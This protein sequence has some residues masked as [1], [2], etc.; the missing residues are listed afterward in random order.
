MNGNS[1]M[2]D[3]DV[4]RAVGDSLSGMPATPPP[5][6]EMIKAR[7][8]AH[9]RRQLIPG[10]AGAAVVAAGAAALAVTTLTPASHPTTRPHAQLAAWTVAKQADGNVRVTIHELRDASQ[11]QRTLR[12]DG[13]P[14]SVGVT[15]NPACQGYF[16]SGTPAQ[17]RAKMRR[18]KMSPVFQLAHSGHSSVIIIHPSALP[19]GTGVIIT[20]AFQPNYN[21]FRI[22][23]VQASPQCTGS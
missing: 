22:G 23:L 13:I 5:P 1:P 15:T 4:L 14:A 19:T 20:P 11:L 6:V 10:M 12:A 7:A 3:H 17:R 2:S 8:R 21:G 18:E 16:T 9:R